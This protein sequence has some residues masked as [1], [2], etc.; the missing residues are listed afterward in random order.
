MSDAA[1][2]AGLQV[3]PVLISGG[4]GTRLWP[5]SRRDFP[6]QFVPLVQGESLL[7][8]TL[9]R[10]AQV[11]ALRPPIVVC[12]EAHRFLVAEQ[13]RQCGA[14]AF[15]LLLEPE[16]R[17]TAPAAALGVLQALEHCTAPER[18]VVA[19][20]PAD[21]VFEDDAAWGQA[22]AAGIE[23]AAEGR[24]VTFGI[25]PSR[26]ET[27]YGYLHCGA[28]L[29]D[30]PGAALEVARFVEKPD[31]AT[32]AQYLASGGYLWNSG[33]FVFRADWFLD[34]LE[35]F[36]PA[37]LK[38]VRAAWSARST[39][40]DFIRPD[41]E[42]FRASPA[43][44]I[45]YALMERVEGV[46]TV[47]LDAG[48]SD[49]GAWDAIGTLLAGDD[50]GN[51]TTGD[52]RLVD[53]ERTTVFADS[54]LVTA[55][56]MRDAVI[57]ETPDAVLVVPRERAQQV[58]ALVAA[59]DA[60]DRPELIAHQRVYRPWGFY[61]TRAAGPRYQVKRI[62]VSPGQQLSMQMHHHRSEHWVVVSGTARVTLDD[63]V[64]L[65]TEN[66]SIYIPLGSRH[67]LDNPGKMDLEL[68]EVQSGGYLGEDDIVRFDDRYGRDSSET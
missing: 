10:L 55:V 41:P 17:N 24:P 59:L 12:N 45:D 60:E 44:S 30:A 63:T 27:G 64:H 43:D 57:V 16:G 2:A 51:A 3:V 11:P 29:A 46:A 50:A 68:I 32:A 49:V 65:L 33:M 38:A 8:R 66:Q 22:V 67:R 5:L 6:K 54:R 13:L 48:W 40:L 53:C 1:A 14:D 4:S 52:V 7:Q 61:E 21:H 56:G 19:V 23:L 9:R 20:F 15:S 25:R 34:S 47:P 35:R 42:A 31:A 18:T 37:M 28:A 39:D 62:L 58:K 36:E 26:P